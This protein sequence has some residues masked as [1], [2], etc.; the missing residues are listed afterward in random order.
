MTCN[1]KHF[2]KKIQDNLDSIP[3]GL[4]LLY[5]SNSCSFVSSKCTCTTLKISSIFSQKH[6]IPLSPLPQRTHIKNS[7]KNIRIF[8]PKLPSNKSPFKQ[9]SKYPELKFDL[10]PS[11]HP[12][13]RQIERVARGRWE[14]HRRLRT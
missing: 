1:S 10:I 13:G 14:S 6:F 5:A 9:E 3:S 7:Y 11:E 12:R 8:Q 4:P 2:E